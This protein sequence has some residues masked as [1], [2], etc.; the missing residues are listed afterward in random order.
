ME[1]SLTTLC[2]IFANTAMV[3]NHDYRSSLT[4][5]SE[6]LWKGNWPLDQEFSH[7]CQDM[8]Y[9][10]WWISIHLGI[11]DQIAGTGIWRFN[12]Y[13]M[14]L[15]KYYI[16]LCCYPNLNNSEKI[17]G[18]IIWVQFHFLYIFEGRVDRIHKTTH[19]T[20]LSFCFFPSNLRSLG[21]KII[22]GR[23]RCEKA[24]QVVRACSVA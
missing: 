15:C 2:S 13:L 21:E 9:G 8:K 20:M 19:I 10:Y 17:F 23:I 3:C 5:V 7:T 16:A 14:L 22:L 6:P 1:E 24:P 4:P 12:N 18:V 11:C